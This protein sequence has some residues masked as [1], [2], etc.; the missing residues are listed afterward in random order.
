VL[1]I[2]HAGALGSAAGHDDGTTFTA[3]RLELAPDLHVGTEDLTATSIR[4]LGGLSSWA[5]AINLQGSIEVDSGSFNVAGPFTGDFTKGGPGT[6][7]VNALGAAGVTEAVIRQGT[8]IVTVNADSPLPVG[9]YG[10]AGPLGHFTF[11]SNSRVVFAPAGSG[12]DV[13]LSAGTGPGSLS[14][15]FVYAGSSTIALDRRNQNSLTLNIGSP[16]F[17]FNPSLGTSSRGVLLFAPAT[18]KLGSGENVKLLD[19]GR[20]T[21]GLVAPTLLLQGNDVDASGGFLTH[22]TNGLQRATPSAATTLQSAGATEL[23]AAATPQSLTGPA[24]VYALINQGQAI[25]LGAHTLKLGTQPFGSSSD[26]SP[27]VGLILN[28][29]AISGGTLSFADHG[30]IYTSLANAT[31]SSQITGRAPF[32]PTILTLA[33]PGTLTLSGTVHAEELYVAGGTLNVEG[34][35]GTVSI[36]PDARLTGSGK[37]GALF[38][39]Q[40]SPGNGPGILTIGYLRSLSNRHTE[41]ASFEFTKRG[42]PDFAAPRASGNDLL[43]VG[44]LVNPN[45]SRALG[46]FD[47]IGIYLDVTG[48][49]QE[50]DILSGGFYSD[51]GDFL[52][53]IDDATFRF[54]LSDPAGSIHFG[55][56]SYRPLTEFG[57]QVSTVFQPADFGA[58]TV[59]GYIMQLEIIPEP[60]TVSLLAL[61]SA[62]LAAFRLRPRRS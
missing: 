24:A 45:L 46:S 31:I 32:V 38:G 47:K 17:R 40:I 2:E 15:A 8:V 57:V 53:F 49:L 1:R 27:R 60:S 13:V 33:G 51:A 50:G 58:G 36:D 37:V 44:D 18:G 16:V 28:G 61:A 19:G 59:N 25:N 42:L 62:G 5:G 11:I 12:S 21:N 26:L 20:L 23:F 14:G 30:V 22:G 52:N 54:Y 43:R 48:S 10:K 4:S 41:L 6:L 7:V 55:G 3:G 35:V 56:A 29:G 9:F 34:V 39:D